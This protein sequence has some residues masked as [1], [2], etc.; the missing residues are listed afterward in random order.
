MGG[1]GD[2]PSRLHWLALGRVPEAAEQL[3]TTLPASH[4]SASFCSRAAVADGICIHPSCSIVV[5]NALALLLQLHRQLT[6]RLSQLPR[7]RC[8]AYRWKGGS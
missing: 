8:Q 3:P 7:S 1:P 6:G 2:L 5:H 4:D